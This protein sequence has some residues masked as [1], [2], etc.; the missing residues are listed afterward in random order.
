MSPG[1]QRVRLAGPSTVPSRQS[2]RTGWTDTTPPPLATPYIDLV[3]PEDRERTG[4]QIARLRAGKRVEWFENRMRRATA[5]R[6]GRR[7][8]QS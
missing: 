4:A 5:R 7:A 1:G 3:H 6:L 2:H 8:T